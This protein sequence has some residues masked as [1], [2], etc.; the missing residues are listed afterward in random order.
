MP[1]G[2]C[3]RCDNPLCRDITITIV[4]ATTRVDS[5]CP[6]FRKIRYAHANKGTIATPCRN[7][8]I[9]C[10]LC[11]DSS[12]QS[13]G[14]VYRGIWRYNMGAHIRTEHKEYASPGNSD[15]SGRLPLPAEFWASMEIHLKEYIS[16]GIDKLLI[17]PPFNQVLPSP[18]SPLPPF[19]GQVFPNPSSPLPPSTPSGGK[20][21]RA[22]TQTT[23]DFPVRKQ[24]RRH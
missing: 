4:G 17:P 16:C 14:Q 19:T 13:R 24:P 1:C 15:N 10:R 8:P 11:P 23:T 9:R 18:S 22:F 2:S 6:L 3:G 21:S 5:K 12:L 7:V 20:R